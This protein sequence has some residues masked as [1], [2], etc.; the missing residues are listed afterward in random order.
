MIRTGAGRS[1]PRPVSRATGPNDGT[2]PNFT[3]SGSS[4]LPTGDVGRLLIFPKFQVE[5]LWSYLCR[6]VGEDVDDR[7]PQSEP[8][9]PHPRNPGTGIAPNPGDGSGASL[10]E[11]GGDRSGRLEGAVS[12]RPDRPPHPDARNL[13]DREPHLTGTPERLR[14]RPVREPATINGRSPSPAEK[15]RRLARSPSDD[16]TSLFVEIP[17]PIYDSEFIRTS[18][19]ACTPGIH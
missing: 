14:L 11:E 19:L 17:S 2:Q 8:T 6:E 16:A 7:T 1:T 15:L 13:Q 12:R 4:T 3:S 5:S 9:K 10:W 18:R